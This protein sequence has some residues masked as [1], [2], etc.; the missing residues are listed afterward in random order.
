MLSSAA[1]KPYRFRRPLV[2]GTISEIGWRATTRR[3]DR[4]KVEKSFELGHAA[5]K[6]R[7]PLRRARCRAGARH[8]VRQPRRAVSHRRQDAHGAALGVAAMDLLRARLQGPPARRLGP[9]LYR[10]VFFRR[11]DR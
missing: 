5:A 9:L 6:S 4:G 1:E 10:A 11:A 7:H 8:V 3:L 2:S